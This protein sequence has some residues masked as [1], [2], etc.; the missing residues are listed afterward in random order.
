MTQQGPGQAEM[1]STAHHED[2]KT[3][4]QGREAS[5]SNNIF[6]EGNGGGGGGL[7]G[8]AR[9]DAGAL[10]MATAPLLVDRGHVDHI[11]QHAGHDCFAKQSRACSAWMG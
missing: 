6:P 2:S 10:S 7:V 3:D 9:G 5:V 1:R 8:Q 4:G 11:A